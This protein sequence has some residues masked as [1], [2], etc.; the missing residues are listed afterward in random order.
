MSQTISLK[1]LEG[2]AWRSVFQDGMWDIY[3]GLLLVAMA[4]N[5]LMSGSGLA[6]D[7]R[8]GVFIGLEIV[9]MVILWAGKRFITLPRMG[10]VKFGKG[11]R[12]RKLWVTVIV[13]LC[14]L[15]GA[16]VFQMGNSATFQ[17]AL[18]NFFPALWAIG[19]M[20][21]FS[22]GAYLLDFNRLYVIG[23]LY[24]L[25]VPTDYLLDRLFGLDLSVLAFGI[26]G[27]AAVAIGLIVM[28]RFMREYPI[29]NVSGEVPDDSGA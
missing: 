15:L 29:P 6:L 2:K 12:S 13:G 8:T 23:V 28:A 18:R 14:V 27:L 4:A 10:R 20:A 21:F 25:P 11:R 22:M 7:I 1:E 24:A 5:A 17:S 3:L 19:C 16:V 9:A 26:P